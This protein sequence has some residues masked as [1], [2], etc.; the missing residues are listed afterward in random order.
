VSPAADAARQRPRLPSV[1]I[2]PLRSRVDAYA[3]KYV[4]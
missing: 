4:T 1:M 2:S 3:G